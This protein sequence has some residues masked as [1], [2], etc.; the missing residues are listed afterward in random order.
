MQLFDLQSDPA[1]QHDLASQHPDVVTRLKNLF[2]ALNR[3]V[4]PDPQA[5]RADKK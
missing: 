2:D 4:P 1:E 5:R 3:D